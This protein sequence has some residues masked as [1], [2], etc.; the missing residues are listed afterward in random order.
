M[1]Q[2]QLPRSF[3]QHTLFVELPRTFHTG[4]GMNHVDW[5]AIGYLIF[6]SNLNY[7]GCL[8]PSVSDCVRTDRYFSTSG[9][10]LENRTV[11][12]LFVSQLVRGE[13]LP[14]NS[15]NSGFQTQSTDYLF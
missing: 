6:L 15:T 1:N 13:D 14:A 7:P 12:F 3:L 9:A 2:T 4:C 10:Q 5:Y 11:L 8:S